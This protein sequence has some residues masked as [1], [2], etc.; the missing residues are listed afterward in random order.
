MLLTP[1]VDFILRTSF[2]FIV[3]CAV[4][5]MTIILGSSYF[6][7][8]LPKWGLVAMSLGLRLGYIVSQPWISEYRDSKAARAH[9]AVIAPHVKENHVELVTKLVEEFDHGYPS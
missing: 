5:Y 6:E 1:G 9:G 7:L 2:D 8:E 3:P 4:I